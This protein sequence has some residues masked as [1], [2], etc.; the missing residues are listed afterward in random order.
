M[1]KPRTNRLVGGPFHGQTFPRIAF[2][3]AAHVRLTYREDG[4]PVPHTYRP[5]QGFRGMVLD[6]LSDDEAWAMART[7]L[8]G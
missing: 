1:G 3:E 5:R 4:R 2:Q 8:D 7:S 6:S